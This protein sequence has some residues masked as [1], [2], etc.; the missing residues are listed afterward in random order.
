MNIN[1]SY[2]IIADHLRSSIFL[3]SDG[4]MPANEGR[5]YV[6]R[7]IMRRAMM[8]INKL[9]S[10]NLKMYKLVPNFVKKTSSAYPYL[11]KTEEL[12]TQTIKIEEERFNK[13]LKNGLEILEKEITQI[14]DDKILSGKIAFKLYDTYGFPLDLT[15]TILDEKNIKINIDEFESEMQIQKER[16]KKNWKGSGAQSDNNIYFELEE[17][18]G[19]TKF[20]GY[21][22]VKLEA[23]IIAILKDG[24]K[25]DKI[26]KGDKNIEIILDK[27]PFY[28]TSG[29]QKGDDGNLILSSDIKGG[30]L[31]SYN[32]VKNIIDIFET[33]KFSNGVFSHF[34]DEVRGAF[35]V[36]DKIIAVIN[37][38]NR[39]FRAQNHSAT[40]LLHFTLRQILGN[41]ITQKGSNVDV[42][43][44][45]FDF[46]HNQALSYEEII[47]I[48]DLVNFYIRQNSVVETKI[49]DIKNAQKEGAMMLFDE[50][51]DD[52]VRVLSMG[53]D[54][55]RAVSVELCG[56]THV[57]NTGNIGLFKIISEKSIAAGIRRIEATTGHFAL[58]YLRIREQ[59]LDIL[60]KSLKIEQKFDDI[61]IKSSDFHHSKKGFD[62]FY[63]FSDE[64]EGNITGDNEIKISKDLL[65]QINDA[66]S[67]KINEIKSKNKE[68]E[69]LKSEKLTGSNSD[70]IIEK[71]ENIN[72]IHHIF[73]GVEAKDFRNLATQIASKKEYKENSIILFFAKN[74]GKI[75]VILSISNDL[76]ARFKAGE[77]I[78]DIIAKIDGKGGGGKPNFA[79]GGGSKKEGIADAINIIKNIVKNAK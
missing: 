50:K 76:T 16:A 19:I 24:K 69:K 7:R 61:N 31:I 28:A 4:V 35:K 20:L 40:H 33:R 29:G 72:F 1:P 53:S 44:L 57:K 38:R 55:S 63:Y 59:K 67:E 26:S 73:E 36:G 64:K 71:I 37:N 74:S 30:D 34:I 47:A 68:I 6:L 13:T 65:N 70:F 66:G 41:H 52:E 23:K 51:Y 32:D 43:A 62:D 60:L 11:L 8:H 46:N 14:A 17:E 54:G 79:M 9:G 2:K 58:E 25:I 15:Q 45:T 12:V 10:D 21:E 56:G 48:E 78:K 3:I 22:E 77:L 27:T 49:M 42:K 39:Q 75:T 18:F 5:G